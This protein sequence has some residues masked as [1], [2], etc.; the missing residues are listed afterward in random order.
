MTETSG[1]RWLFRVDEQREKLGIGGFERGLDRK[2]GIRCQSKDLCLVPACAETRFSRIPMSV[3]WT[4]KGELWS[5][6]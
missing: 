6:N 3:D 2:P 5:E 1:R 4:L